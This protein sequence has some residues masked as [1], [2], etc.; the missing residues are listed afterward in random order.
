MNLKSDDL[1]QILVVPQ[2]V[3]AL[4]EVTV[5]IFRTVQ[6]YWVVESTFRSVSEYFVPADGGLFWSAQL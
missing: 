6:F 1:W 3:P 5:V 4:I 2:V